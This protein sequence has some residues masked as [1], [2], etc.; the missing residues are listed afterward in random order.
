MIKKKIYKKSI[1]KVI[2]SGEILEDFPSSQ[3]KSEISNLTIYFQNCS[4]SP[5]NPIGRKKK[6][7]ERK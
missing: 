4:R 3:E 7:K 1:S 2:L 6:K 5:T